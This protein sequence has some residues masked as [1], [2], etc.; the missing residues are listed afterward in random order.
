MIDVTVISKEHVRVMLEAVS[1][2]VMSGSV[3]R[4]PLFVFEI[5]MDRAIGL[6][7]IL[8]SKWP[9][10]FAASIGEVSQY[11]TAKDRSRLARGNGLG[12]LV[13]GGGVKSNRR[14]SDWLEGGGGI[15]LLR[16]A[17]FHWSSGRGVKS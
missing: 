8:P 7:T 15:I 17:R 1:Y 11:V 9:V 14:R 13:I 6:T 16:I 4:S 10:S 3:Y 5:V 2:L 12:G